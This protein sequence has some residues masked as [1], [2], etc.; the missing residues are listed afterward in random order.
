V[1]GYL[2]VDANDDMTQLLCNGVYYFERPHRSQIVIVG[3]IVLHHG[4]TKGSDMTPE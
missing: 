1:E 4:V 2:K 3:Y